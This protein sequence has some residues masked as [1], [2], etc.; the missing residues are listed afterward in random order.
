MLIS[1]APIAI[2]VNTANIPTEAARAEAIQRP[3]IPQPAA[4][5]ESARSRDSKSFSDQKAET[6]V[7]SADSRSSIKPDQEESESSDD[8][9]ESGQAGP[10]SKQSAKSPTD[11]TQQEVEQVTKLRSRDREVR[12]HEQAHAAAGGSL[13][14]APNLDYTTGPDG[15]RYATS[16]EVSIDSSPV[17]GDPQATINKL[18]QV[19]SAALAPANPSSQDR[20]VAAQASS[21]IQQAQVELNLQ[22]LAVNQDEQTSGNALGKTD[23]QQSSSTAKQRINPLNPVYARR[24]AAQLNQKILMS[25]I[26]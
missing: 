12:N 2:P 13:A 16:G 20:K 5:A 6:A 10:S 4:A 3:K 14:G 8:G 7:T 9:D 25:L 23:A 15:K 26:E 22:T 11:L 21:G 18:R 1:S 17:T 24:Q 19:Q